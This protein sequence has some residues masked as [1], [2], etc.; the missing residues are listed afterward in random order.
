MSGCVDSALYVYSEAGEKYHDLIK[1]NPQNTT[2]TP[3]PIA[4]FR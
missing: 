2:I 3:V 4:E 1:Q